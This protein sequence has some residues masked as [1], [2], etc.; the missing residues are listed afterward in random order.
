MSSRSATLLGLGLLLLGLAASTAGLGRLT[1]GD[2]VP[3]APSP[4]LSTAPTRPPQ[5][6]DRNAV[7]QAANLSDAFVSIAEAVTPAVVRISAEQTDAPT[8]AGWFPRRFQE[9]FGEDP[10]SAIRLEPTPP[11][12]AGGTG[13]LVSSDGYILTNDHVVQNA[14]RILVELA[15]RRIWTA[16]LVGRDPTTDVAVIKIDGRDLPALALGNSDAARVGE[17]VIAIGN[18]GFDDASTLDF[19]VTG[20][21]ISAKG[22]PLDLIPQGLARTDPAAGAYA[23]EDFLQTDAVINPGNSGGPL[24]N[25]RGEVIGV[26]TAIASTTGFNQG[27]AFAIPAN[28]AQRVM[29]DLIAHGRV[30]RPLL[31]VSIADVTPED[32]EAYDLPAIAGV[33]VDDFAADSPAREAGLL[34]H[35]VIVSIDGQRVERVGQ[36]Q[37]MV[38]LRDPGEAMTVGYVRWGRAGEAVVTLTEAP[39]T[40]VSIEERPVESARPAAGLGFEVADMDAAAAREFGFAQS[41]G[42]VIADVTPYGAAD[43][44]GV[45]TGSRLLAVGRTQIRGV[46]DARAAL[47][48]AARGQVV[49]LLLELPD[50]RTYI[51]NVRV[52]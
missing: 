10:D 11:P 17:W 48:A 14:T 13:F 30:R 51:A 7:R 42:V 52:P 21:I 45:L 40:S 15:D 28:L 47:R 35:D 44:R 46:R 29:K 5:M 38:A 36:L 18:P 12:V 3:G 16:R 26:N 8:A 22:R 9:L 23:I 33:R 4:A 43:R 32:A 50:G 19:T 37:R 25:L 34:R 6:A 31:G 41:G 39:L 49:S 24:V 27:Y 20:G 2:P 1:G